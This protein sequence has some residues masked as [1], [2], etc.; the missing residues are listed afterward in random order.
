MVLNLTEKVFLNETLVFR[1]LLGTNS[2]KEVKV[3]KGPIN[4]ES[5][6]QT[7]SCNLS[8]GQEGLYIMEPIII[9]QCQKEQL[10]KILNTEIVLH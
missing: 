8:T 9:A 5:T 6:F 10:Q 4:G 1:H 3:N 7:R 2:S